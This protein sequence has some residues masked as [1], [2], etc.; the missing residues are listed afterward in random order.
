MTRTVVT[1]GAGFIGS[2]LTEHLLSV[3]DSVV[4]IDDFSTG[5]K[6]NLRAVEDHQ[7]L[8]VVVG[9]VTDHDVVCPA[10]E[11]AD[12][13]YHLAATVGVRR[14]LDDPLTSHCA[15]AGQEPCNRRR[16]CDHIGYAA[17]PVATI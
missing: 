15:A 12:E 7:N 6:S 4:V 5:R 10:I 13:V 3:G 14:V 11:G 1:G 9:S 8:T 16:E 2:H 17:M